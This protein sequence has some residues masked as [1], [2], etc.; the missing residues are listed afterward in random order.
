V[1]WK[2]V[3]GGD[4][5]LTRNKGERIIKESLLDSIFIGINP[6]DRNLLS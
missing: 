4:L 3:F 5:K 2:P 1:A 6:L